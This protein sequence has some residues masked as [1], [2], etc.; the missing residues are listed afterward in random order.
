MAPLLSRRAVSDEKRGSSLGV[1]ETRGTG[2]SYGIERENKM[3]KRVY[4]F[5][6]DRVFLGREGEGTPPAL[7]G[8]GFSFT[9][10]L[11]AEYPDHPILISSPKILK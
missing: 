10:L 1:R 9:P 6:G 5:L 8:F 2:V 3:G 4:S 7:P 11:R